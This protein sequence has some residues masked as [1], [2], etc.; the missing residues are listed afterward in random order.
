MTPAEFDAA[1][2]ELRW[3]AA[4]FTRRTGLVPNTAWRWRKGT[5]PIPEWVP[6]YLGMALEIQR[7]HAR[8]VAPLRGAAAPAADPGADD[9]AAEA[10]ETGSRGA[11][12]Q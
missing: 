6:E 10:P 9:E 1:L 7:L 2:A 11:S 4:D 12:L 3:K 8:F 5:T